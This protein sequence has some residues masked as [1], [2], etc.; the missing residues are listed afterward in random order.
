MKCEV[1]NVGTELLLGQSVNTNAREIGLKLA[2]AGID[3]YCQ[4]TVGDNLER[5]VI[6]IRTALTRADAVILTGGLG[7]TDDDLTRDAVAVALDR[8]L[9]LSPALERLI[10][11]KL[12]K[13]EPTATDKTMRQALLPAGAI[14]IK[15]TL[16]TA[17]GFVVEHN[18]SLIAA[19]PGVPAEM[20][21]ML[22]A[23]IIPRLRVSS[24]GGDVILSRVLKVYGLGEIEVESRI[25]DIID[26]QTNPTIAPLILRGAVAVR[27]TAKAPDV[28]SAQSMIANIE[29]KLRERLG[30]SVFGSDASEMEG[31]V[32]ALLRSQRLSL[33][34]AESVTGGMIGDRITNVAGSSAYFVGGIVAYDNEIK[35]RLLNVSPQ[36]LLSH[37]AVSAPTAEEMAIGARAALGTD[38]AIAVTGIAGPGGGS[39]DKPVGLVFFALAAAD[40]IVCAKKTFH[41]SRNDIRFKTSQ[42]ALN[43]LRLYLL[44]RE[45]R[46]AGAS[47]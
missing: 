10:R 17:A 32:G 38:L 33:A 31:E 39:A 34:T 20:S 23:D 27:L 24:G 28:G 40:S 44:E 19:T 42:Y 41:G 26:A 1:I 5:I 45:R 47:A 22:D 11:A 13:F 21:R 25:Q 6:A 30:D 12:H 3:C 36:T 8:P 18:G 46:C 9:Q 43:M 4:T 29:K 37:G 16:G 35:Q 15:P 2:A 7:S 14:A